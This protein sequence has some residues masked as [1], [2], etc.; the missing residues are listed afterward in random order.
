MMCTVSYTPCSQF[1]PSSRSA[2]NSSYAILC[3][4][5]ALAMP[6]PTGPAPINAIRLERSDIALI[7]CLRTKPTLHARLR[8]GGFDFGQQLHK[9]LLT[10]GLVVP[11]FRFRQLRDVHRAELRPAHRAEFRFLVEIVGQVFVVHGLGSSRIQ[12]KL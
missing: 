6:S 9:F 10:L 11:A 4:S 2:S 8:A 1:P 7:T 3:S 5:K 12:R